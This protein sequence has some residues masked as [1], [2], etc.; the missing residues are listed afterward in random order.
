MDGYYIRKKEEKERGTYA[1]VKL[2]KRKILSRDM[3]I[4]VC[5]LICLFL[6]SSYGRE[7]MAEPQLVQNGNVQITMKDEESQKMIAGGTFTCMNVGTLEIE[8]GELNWKFTKAFAESGL[9]MN[10]I[11]TEAFAESLWKYAQSQ[12]MDGITKKIDANGSV[13]FENIPSGIYLMVQRKAAEGYYKVR[14]F[15]VTIPVQEENGWC[16]DVDASPKMEKIKKKSDVPENPKVP[17]KGQKLPQTGQLNWPVPVLAISGMLLFITG[18]K[19]RNAE[20]EK[21]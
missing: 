2:E 12:S 19:I 15:V 6:F 21:Y 4:I 5:T 3:W 11:Q 8:E 20:D 16:Y 7:V 9:D 1:K 14:P 10:E 17:E 13:R 18:W